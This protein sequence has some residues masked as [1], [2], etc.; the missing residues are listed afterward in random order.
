M[1]EDSWH[2][3]L[4]RCRVINEGGWGNGD[5]FEGERD[6]RPVIIKTYARKGPM[7]RMIG[8]LLIAREYQAYRLLEGC[9]GIPRV[10]FSPRRDTLLMEKLEG[11][12]ISVERLGAGGREVIDNLLAAISQM[13]ERGVYHLDLRNRGNVLVSPD[14]RIWILDF[15]SRVIVRGKNPISRLIAGLCR[16]FDDYGKGKWVAMLDR[17]GV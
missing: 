1:V 15:A 3:D 11:E 8:R 5:V 2:F 12:R 17:Q 7:I 14:N 13:H 16:R 9:A 4:D 6:G 10:Y